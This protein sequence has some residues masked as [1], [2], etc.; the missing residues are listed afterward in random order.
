MWHCSKNTQI[1][2]YEK[3]KH[4]IFQIRREKTN[5]PKNDIGITGYLFTDR[6]K[7]KLKKSIKSVKN[8]VSISKNIEELHVL[9]LK[10]RII[11]QAKTQ[12]S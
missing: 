2:Q 4:V 10:W 3:I 9:I 5:N 11:S 12:K 1:D 6:L 8:D 7:T